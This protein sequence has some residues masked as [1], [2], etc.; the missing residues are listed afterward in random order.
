MQSV[1]TVHNVPRFR[2]PVNAFPAQVPKVIPSSNVRPNPVQQ[3]IDVIDAEVQRLSDES[4]ACAT[5]ILTEKRSELSQAGFAAGGAKAEEKISAAAATVEMR[6]VLP[7]GL[8]GGRLIVRNTFIALEVKPPALAIHRI[9]SWPGAL[10]LQDDALADAGVC[11]EASQCSG[12]ICLTPC[13]KL[14]QDNMV[15][16]STDDELGFSGGLLSEFDDSFFTNS[17]GWDPLMQMSQ[18]PDLSAPLPES[19]IP[20]GLTVRNTFIEVD[21]NRPTLR[22]IAT[23]PGSLG[24]TFCSSLSELSTNDEGSQSSESESCYDSSVSSMKPA[25]PPVLLPGVTARVPMTMRLK[26]GL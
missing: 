10:N 14:S 13:Q 12:V 5:K 17:S 9:A 24:G 20:D 21:V 6:N 22:K 18:L 3:L 8:D 2:I 23:C 16:I 25:K 11:D 1:P 4:Y 7:V 26:Y 19:G 15:D